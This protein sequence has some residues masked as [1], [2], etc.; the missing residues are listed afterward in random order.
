MSGCNSKRQL[1]IDVK[2]QGDIKGIIPD[3]DLEP[4][5]QVAFLGKELSARHKPEENIKN[6][7][8]IA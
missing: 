1:N 4:E 8:C 7:C 3:A 5:S 2:L 6:K